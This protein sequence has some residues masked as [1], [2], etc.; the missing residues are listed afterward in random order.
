MGNAASVLPSEI[1]A[2]DCVRLFGARD[3][4][5][6]EKIFKHYGT[7]EGLVS[8]ETFLAIKNKYFVEMKAIQ[9]VSDVATQFDAFFSHNW[10]DSPD[11][12]NH[13]RVQ[14]VFEELQNHGLSLWFD[15][16]EMR[17]DYVLRL[18]CPGFGLSYVPVISLVSG[19][20]EIRDKMSEGIDESKC[21]VAFVTETYHSKVRIESAL[22]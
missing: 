7:K 19:R 18:N 16:V 14:M 4:P 22:L 15:A 8:K 13:S 3:G 5:A 17:L 20:G 2:D 21:F 10:G 12:L 11:H 1:S 9:G 6:Y